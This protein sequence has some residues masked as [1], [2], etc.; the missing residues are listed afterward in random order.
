MK[1]L[2]QTTTTS[3]FTHRV[4][5]AGEC[6]SLGAPLLSGWR[7]PTGA[8]EGNLVLLDKLAKP[9]GVARA[10]VQCRLDWGRISASGRV[11]LEVSLE[12]VL[13]SPALNDQR[14]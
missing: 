11:T 8:A 3:E 10:G 13:F 6:H 7:K 2:V 9:R 5:A 1:T 14:E 4:P 12:E